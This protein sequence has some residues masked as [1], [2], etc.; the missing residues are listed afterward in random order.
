MRNASGLAVVGFLSAC[1]A[2]EPPHVSRETI[3]AA[4][5]HAHLQLERA[6]A[7]PPEAGSESS[8]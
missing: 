6:T 8:R 7:P 3:Q 1:A 2:E 4:I 5:D